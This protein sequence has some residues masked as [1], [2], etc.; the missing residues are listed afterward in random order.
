MKRPVVVTVIASFCVL[1]A[2]YLSAVGAVM[3]VAPSKIS[4]IRRAP[5]MYGLGLANP[6]VA[7]IVGAIWGIVGWGLLR[8]YNWARWAVM[9][10]SIVGFSSALARIPAASGS[11]RIL[12][13]LGLNM[14]VR[15]AVV[16]YL[17]QA[18]SVI[19]SFTKR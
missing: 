16:W 12:V 18:P 7:I 15:A 19:D 8:L 11:G 5:L 13:F 10:L 4:I 14:A 3:L 9:F 6:Y 1:A 17:V 2:A